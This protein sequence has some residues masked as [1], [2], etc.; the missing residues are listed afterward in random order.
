MR[1]WQFGTRVYE[2]PSVLTMDRL[3]GKWKTNILWYIWRGTNRFNA[4]CRALPEVRRAVIARQIRS[5]EK[6]GLIDHTTLSEKPL[7]I[8]YGLTELGYSLFPVIELLVAWGSSHGT[9]VGDEEFISG[10]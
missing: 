6:D 8:E 3:R 1:Q 7:H 9:C 4:I 5:M 10:R 2:C